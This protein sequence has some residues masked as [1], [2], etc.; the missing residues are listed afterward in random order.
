[1][2]TINDYVT[3]HQ[4]K[5]FEAF[6]LNEADK[7]CL[8][9][10]GYFCFE[11]LDASIDV[12]KDVL[13]QE[14]FR[15]YSTGEKTLDRNFLA[16]KSRIDL[17]KTV[18]ESDRF[19]DL[20]VSY[21]VNDVDEEY[22]RQFA[23]MVFSLPQLDYR[24]LVF[25][26]TD[27][28]LI[29]WK[30]DFKLSY[31]REIPAHRS[32]LKYLEEILSENAGSFTLSGHSKGGNLA[33]YAAA[34]VRPDLRSQITQIYMLDSPGLNEADLAKEGYRAIRDK[35]RVIR[36]EESIVGVMLYN[37]IEPVI[38]QSQGVGIMQH[39]LTNWQMDAETGQWLIA[40]HPTEL[41]RNLEKTFKQWTDD[42]SSQE[43]K[44]LFD[45]LF[46]TLMS[47]GITS[48]NDLAVNREFVSK[49]SAI[50]IS[51]YSIGAEK[52][53]LLAKSAKLFL[54]AFMGHS[55]LATL[56]KDRG[57]LSLPDLNRFRDYWDDRRE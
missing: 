7:M 44:L 18:A 24:Q 38:V 52:K 27:D 25:R 2:G 28:T 1:M 51:F 26:G 48:I 11:E 30:E 43:L 37:D 39:A 8:N 15:P 29:G 10:L 54:G 16:T 49:L 46:D 4:D 12:T 47:S 35:V 41:S 31:V 55:K 22:E 36:P 20:H 14:V 17:L 33:L 6:P 57:N 53:F 3:Q 13:V 19:A 50:L 5:T 32:S 21:Y 42:L 34:N 23:A 56:T 45:T 40:E 9:E